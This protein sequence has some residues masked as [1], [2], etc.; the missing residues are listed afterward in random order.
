M[1][2]LPICALLLLF[3]G[4]ASAQLY[5]SGS[6]GALGPLTPTE[7]TVVPLPED[8]VLHYSVID[9]PEGV[10]VTFDRNP[11]NTVVWLL[12]S[13]AVTIA[14]TVDVSGS[15]GISSSGLSGISALGGVGGPGASDGASVFGTTGMW[16]LGP[17]SG[18]GNNGSLTRGSGGASPVQDGKKA[19]SASAGPG[20]EAFGDSGYQLLHGGSGGGSANGFAGGGG[21]GGIIIASSISITVDGAVLARGGPGWGN[22]GAGGAGFV[23][24]AAPE[25][26]GLGTLDALANLNCGASGQGAC[27]G[28]GMVRVESYS[29]TGDL[30]ANAAPSLILALPLKSVPYPA[31]QRPRLQI[32]QIADKTPIAGTN[33][34]HAMQAPGVSLP[35]S[36]TVTV[37]VSAQFVDPGTTVVVVVNALGK[38]RTLYTATLE[39]SFASSSGSVDVLVP[40]AHDQGLIEAYIPALPV[41]SGG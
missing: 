31:T 8:G 19:G 30:E 24:L 6:T 27:G 11:H 35:E 34:G 39:G 33:K 28:N 38:G 32:A 40:A 22:A 9:I 18:A 13:D 21:G 23:R 7:D 2:R 37:V 4:P 3:A 5:E 14:G 36:G 25:I 41:P 10:T 20:G 15:A 29:L 1:R 16:G 17:G 12:A 26:G